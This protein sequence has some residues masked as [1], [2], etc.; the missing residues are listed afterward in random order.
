MNSL[1]IHPAEAAKLRPYAVDALIFPPLT[2]AP[3]MS[4]SS[5]DDPPAEDMLLVIDMRVIEGRLMLADDA[6][7]YGD[8]S[9]DLLN[10][11]RAKWPG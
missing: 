11:V 8:V 4:S 7:H 6:E 3:S 10:E 5:I 1:D 9:P 2:D